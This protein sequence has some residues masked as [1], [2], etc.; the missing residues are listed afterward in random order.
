M[1]E[2][3][4]MDSCPY[5]RKV[6]DYLRTHRIEYT[7]HDVTNPEQARELMTL[8]GKPQVPFLADRENNVYLYD[9]AQIIKYLEGNR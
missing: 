4:S 1:L 7:E 6:K 3:F 9:S 8:G 2:L 5:C